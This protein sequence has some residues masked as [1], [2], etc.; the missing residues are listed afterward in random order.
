ML[1]TMTDKQARFVAEYLVD[2]NATQAAIRAGYSSK[3]AYSIGQRLMKDPAIQAQIQAGMTERQERTELSQDYVIDNLRE[4]VSRCMNAE[5]FKPYG[6]LKALEL[7]GKHL[8]MFT[9]KIQVKEETGPLV[10]MWQGED[11]TE[12]A[13]E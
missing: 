8:R 2:C 10:F 6:A 3:T 11:S 9:D 5:D 12:Q 1:W 7:L 4:I 13:G